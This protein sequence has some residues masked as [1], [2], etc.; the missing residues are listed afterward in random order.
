M[1]NLNSYSK[2]NHDLYGVWS[3]VGVFANKQDFF[4]SDFFIYKYIL[5][6]MNEKEHC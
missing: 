3:A 2:I 1:I 5:V 4:G 6:A